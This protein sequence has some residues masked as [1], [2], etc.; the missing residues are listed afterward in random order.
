MRP[1]FQPFDKSARLSS[2]WQ[3]RGQ[4]FL[5]K[6]DWSIRPR[7][8]WDHRIT[9]IANSLPVTTFTE[10]YI[11]CLRLNLILVEQMVSQIKFIDEDFEERCRRNG[12]NCSC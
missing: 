1:V 12:E 8:W 11:L 10:D 6:S 3:G 4:E 2:P 7:D 5:P 9:R